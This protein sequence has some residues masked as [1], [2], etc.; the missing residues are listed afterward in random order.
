MEEA[1]LPYLQ[2]IAARSGQGQDDA[3]LGWALF[4]AGRSAE[5][6]DAFRTARRHGDDDAETVRGAMLAAAAARAALDRHRGA[7]E[8]LPPVPQRG[9]KQAAPSLFGT[10]AFIAAFT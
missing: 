7:A 1:A 2:D 4:R 8:K 6:A 10:T 9:W 3:R 5:A